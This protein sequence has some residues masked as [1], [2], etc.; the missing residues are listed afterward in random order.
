[1]SLDLQAP[2]PV[3]ERQLSLSGCCAV[4]DRHR[5]GR[6]FYQSGRGP[7][8]VVVTYALDGDGV[9]VRLPSYN[10]LLQYSRDA[11]TTLEVDEVCS[12]SGRSATVLVTGKPHICCPRS[13][14]LSCLEHWPHG[15]PTTVLK[16]PLT[17]VRGSEHPA[18]HDR[19]AESD[20]VTGSSC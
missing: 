13:T 8:A 11:E 17:D 10:E 18:P 2:S 20:G 4:L 1:M 19:P 7:R 9:L 5:E 14:A 6:M 12:P 16:L 3:A 15:V